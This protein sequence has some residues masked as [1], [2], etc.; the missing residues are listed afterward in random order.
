MYEETSKKKVKIEWIETTLCML[1]GITTNVLPQSLER[2]LQSPLNSR[3]SSY[4]QNEK[5]IYLELYS[6]KSKTQWTNLR[7]R[8]L[9]RF[10]HPSW[11]FSLLQFWHGG[12]VGENSIFCSCLRH[13]MQ[14]FKIII[15]IQF[16]NLLKMHNVKIFFEGHCQLIAN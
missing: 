10:D 7:F 5:K 9:V 4:F 1:L 16:K 13:W 12:T 11:F 2:N 3:L 14:T 8:V 15:K 6:V